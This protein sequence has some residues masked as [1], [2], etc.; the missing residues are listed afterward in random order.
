MSTARRSEVTGGSTQVEP[1]ASANSMDTSTA[2]ARRCTA[3]FPGAFRPPHV[4]HYATVV[5]LAERGDVDEVVIVVSNRCRTIPQTTKALDVDVAL[6]IWDIYLQGLRKVRIEVAH[7]GAVAHALDYVDQC[8]PGDSLLLCTGMEAIRPD[9]GR[10]RKAIARAQQ[11]RVSARVVPA[12]PDVAPVRAT[13]LRAMLAE[14]ER[15]QQAFEAALP[16]H[17]S[18]AERH[19]VWR[20]CMDGMIEY[21]DIVQSKLRQHF[22]THA[23][24]DIADIRVARADKDDEI[25]R[26]R[27][28]DD[29]QVFVKRAHDT[30]SAAQ[31]GQ[32]HAH[33]PRKR[34]KAE[35]LALKHLNSIA[36]EDV[37]VPRVVHFDKT[38][39]TLVLTEVCPG[40]RPLQV[41]LEAGRFDPRVTGAAARFLARSHA[42]TADVGPLWD[43]AAADLRHW[44]AML[45]LRT[46]DIELDGLPAQCRADLCRLAEASDAARTGGIV[47]LDFRPKNILVRGADIGVIDFEQSCSIGDAAYDLGLFLGEYLL[48]SYGAGCVSECRQALHGAL[49]EY[50][51]SASERWLRIR[52]RVVAFTGACMLH[53][54]SIEPRSETSHS[55]QRLMSTGIGLLA[56][57]LCS[58]EDA[59]QLLSGALGK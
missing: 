7:T 11:A 13:Q 23:L 6:R 28:G 14:G 46:T 45:A 59:F 25:F 42:L 55:R 36:G 4:N 53:G 35:R 12:G 8:E 37:E 47:N 32:R 43:D 2:G 31:L 33:K 41:D 48:W 22:R 57:G 54:L 27:L 51:S 52:P 30:V 21:R 24:G 39:K 56:A 38:T 16:W 29:A 40:G 10:F 26:V 44:R 1:C 17:L 18:A 3:L 49:S 20:I 19:Q 34:L 9:G 58:G 15:G 50:R 5:G